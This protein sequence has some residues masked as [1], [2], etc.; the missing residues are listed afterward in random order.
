MNAPMACVVSGPI[1]SVATY[2]QR[3]L[4]LGVPVIRLRTS[5]RVPPSLMEPARE[6]LASVLGGVALRPPKIPVVSNVTRRLAHRRAGHRSGLLGRPH[7]QTGVVGPGLQTL[8]ADAPSVLLEVGVGHATGDL[9][10]MQLPNGTPDPVPTFP[11]RTTT[12]GT[13]SR[14]QHGCGRWGWRS[15]SPCCTPCLAVGC[16]CRDTRSSA[17]GSGSRPTPAAR[18]KRASARSRGPGARRWTT[19]SGCRAG[20]DPRRVA[21]SDI[22]ASTGPWVVVRDPDGSID[23]LVA[24]RRTAGA[25]VVTVTPGDGFAADDD[26]YTVQ[27]DQPADFEQLIDGLLAAGVTPR[28]IVHGWML[29][30]MAADPFDPYAT[31]QALPLAFSSLLWLTQALANHGLTEDVRLTVLSHRAQAVI[32][33]DVSSPVQA[34]TTGPVRAMPMEF[35][36]LTIRQIDVDAPAGAVDAM[37]AELDG[38]DEL[39]AY[40]NGRRWVPLLAAASVGAAAARLRARSLRQNGV[41]LI[42]GGLGGLGLSIAEGSVRTTPS[43]RYYS[44]L[45]VCACQTSLHFLIFMIQTSNQCLLCTKHHWL[46]AVLT[47]V[48]FSIRL[49]A[50]CLFTTRHA[51]A[52][53]V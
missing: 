5:A 47:R 11:R 26:A 18:R 25:R 20:A 7:V 27:P 50:V 1:D 3:C 9:A 30:P 29:S 49:T 42:T 24:R 44:M 32:G 22:D 10:R 36:D 31:Q 51:Y 37:L 39:V 40:R 12:R 21:G 4:E 13:C 23:P 45:A 28:A 14:P 43:R 53:I 41:Y 17:N 38:D 8:L 19:G 52:W 6:A 35:P 16:P 46:F 48:A 2:E 15:T 34:L 33:G